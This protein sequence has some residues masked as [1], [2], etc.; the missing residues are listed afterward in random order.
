MV[1][2]HLLCRNQHRGGDVRRPQKPANPPI[3]QNRVTGPTPRPC[4][5]RR[6]CDYA[7][8][9]FPRTHHRPY[10]APWVLFA[11]IVAHD[12]DESQRR[13]EHVFRV[14][15]T[16]FLKIFGKF[17]SIRPKHGPKGQR[18]GGL[19]FLKPNSLNSMNVGATRSPRDPIPGGLYFQ[20]SPFGTQHQHQQPPPGHIRYNNTSRIYK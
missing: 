13:F 12:G 19:Y 3:P 11:L 17:K 10:F 20:C 1:S 14:F 18:P 6:S 5:S 4:Q 8:V 15:P 2:S 7:S 16:Q 9:L